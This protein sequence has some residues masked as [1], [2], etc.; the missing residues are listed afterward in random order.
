MRKNLLNILAL[1]LFLNP[2]DGNLG[3]EGG[4][5]GVENPEV[6]PIGDKVV[7]E[8][9]AEKKE[10][11]EDVL[12]EDKTKEEKEEKEEKKEDEEFDLDKLDTTLEEEV[13]PI[14][15][16]KYEALREK[17]FNIE[18]KEFQGQIGILA[19]CGMEDPEMQ[20]KFLEMSKQIQEAKNKFL[21]TSN[22]K[23]HLK[24]N[25]SPEAFASVTPIRNVFKEIYKDHENKAEIQKLLDTQIFSNP[26][27][28]DLLHNFQRFI[29]GKEIKKGRNPG[30]D[31]SGK[32][33]K[34]NIGGGTLDFNTIIAQYNKER[35]KLYKEG[36]V[37]QANL[38]KLE[39]DLLNKVSAKDKERVKEYF[40]I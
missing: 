39:S 38:Q 7:S 11:E 28:V 37:N 30:G 13:E 15:S 20:I 6:T 35:A 1:H 22:V 16:T 9:G 26:V 14:D 19:K 24:E 18:S 32:V 17:G 29:E 23:K 12:P 27:A 10:D 40:N 36:K 3:G 33:G 34:T 21:T 25:L 5:E 2:T 4:G 31:S 8:D